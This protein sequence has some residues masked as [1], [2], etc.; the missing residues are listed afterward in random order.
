MT[1]GPLPQEVVRRVLEDHR[2]VQAE[3]ADL[4]A[5]LARLA[6][7]W[8]ELGAERGQPNARALTRPILHHQ[9]GARR[10]VIRVRLFAN[11]N[12]LR[13]AVPG[14]NRASLCV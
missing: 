2:R 7:A 13:V 1:M 3:R 9:I 8:V 5:Q 10:D 4:K 12:G 14:P 6:P 11:A